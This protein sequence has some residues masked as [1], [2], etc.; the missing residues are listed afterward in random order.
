MT[1]PVNTRVEAVQQLAS[2]AGLPHLREYVTGLH[3]V[4]YAHPE[5][6]RGGGRQQR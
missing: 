4:L 2:Q 6:R 3:V 1:L 5:S